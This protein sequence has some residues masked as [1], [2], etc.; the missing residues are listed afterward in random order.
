MTGKVNIQLIDAYYTDKKMM[1]NNLNANIYAKV[2][3]P[4]NISY[5]MNF[6]PRYEWVDD[7]EHK[8]S[9]HPGWADLGGTAYMEYSVK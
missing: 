4:Y 8:S 6:S 7:Y 2:T 3:L 9:N 1:T 5:Q